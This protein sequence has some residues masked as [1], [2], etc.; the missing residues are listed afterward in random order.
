MSI[1]LNSFSFID[2]K[3]D[4]L[5]RTSKRHSILKYAQSHDLYDIMK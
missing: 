1:G 3:Q 5:N 4:K 2:T